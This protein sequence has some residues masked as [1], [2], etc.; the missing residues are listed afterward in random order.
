MAEAANGEL[1]DM[2]SEGEIELFK[3][4]A[5]LFQAVFLVVS[6]ARLDEVDGTPVATPYALSLMPASK[7]D[8][9]EEKDIHLVANLDVQKLL[10]EMEPC[11]FH[12]NPFT[13]DRGLFGSL[14]T[15]IGANSSGFID[16]LGIVIGQFFLSKTCNQSDVLEVSLGFPN[17]T[18]EKKYRNHRANLLYKPFT[19]IEPRRVWGAQSP[20][21]LFLLQEL[22]RRGLTPLLQV[23][24]FDNGFIHQ[25][26]YGLWKD[27][28][29]RYVPGLITEPDMFF[30]D[31]KLAVF[32]DSS[33]YHR[34]GKAKAKDA[35]IDEKLAKIGL[36][37]VRVPGKLIVEDVKAAA[38]LVSNALASP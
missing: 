8:A 28:D 19:K 31:K 27:I 14:G 34:G 26:L 29:F 1:R 36:S 15:V 3:E 7:R 25:S 20:I 21:E 9:I 16:E 18:A 6:I 30:P 37:S 23:L 4:K 38:D 11:Y 33:R 22:L 24:V 5:T 35:A 2:P 12:F 13:G 32:C 10:R 17:E